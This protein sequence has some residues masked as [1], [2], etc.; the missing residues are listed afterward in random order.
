M[1][2][3]NLEIVRSIYSAWAKGDFTS[4]E[5]ADDDIEF[6]MPREAATRGLAAMGRN[7]ADWLRAWDGVA[8]V[9]KEFKVVG[10]QVLVFHE[11]RGVGKRSG[12]PAADF[13]GA[14]VFTLRE[15]KV[16][17]LILCVSPSD[18]LKAAGLS[19]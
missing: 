12:I 19:E 16:V 13:S 15:G 5:W 7:F 9:P 8:T 10:D 3:E 2:Q 4:V 1:S 18:A 11:F 14:C 17:R 6:A